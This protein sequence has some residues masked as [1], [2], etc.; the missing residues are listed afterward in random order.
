MICQAFWNA[1][2][3]PS[4][5]TTLRFTVM[6]C[7]GSSSE[8]SDKLNRDLLAQAKKLNDHKLTLNLE[9]T[10]CMLVGINGK[11]ESKVALTVSIFEHTVN[12]I[13]SFKYLGIFI[14]SDF[15]W[16]NHVEYITGK[17]N[18]RLGL[19][20]RMKPFSARLLFNNSLVIPLFGYADLVW[21]DKNNV[22]LLQFANLV[23]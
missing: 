21:G 20:N 14:L 19:L 3:G 16:T 8:L 10:K 7:Y 22:I 9:K 12:N 17:I 18:Q 5:Q 2:V 23:E 4:M 13:N 11:L 6:V 15:T 1:T